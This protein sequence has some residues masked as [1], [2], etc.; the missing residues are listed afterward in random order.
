MGKLSAGDMI[1]KEAMYHSKCIL[2]LYR[3]SKHKSCVFDDNE[4]DFEKQVHGQ[5]FAELALYMEQTANED[6]GYIFKLAD[7]AKSYKTR[8]GELGGHTLDRVHTTKLLTYHIQRLMLDIE[9][10][11]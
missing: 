6:K 7:L 4:N 10:L 5:V 2:V 1:A 3:K 11:K 9:N 8:V